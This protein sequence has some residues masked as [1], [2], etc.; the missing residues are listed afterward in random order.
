M[1]AA[2]FGFREGVGVESLQDALHRAAGDVTPTLLATHADKRAGLTGLAAATGLAFVG[3]PEAALVAQQTL[4]Q[5]QASQTARRTG[6][7]AEASALAAA[8]PGARLLGPRQ[9]SADR[10]AT[11]ALAISADAD[12]D[13]R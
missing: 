6:S 12:G 2:G 3:L 7:V 13:D 8:G 10:R 4:T 9:I 1:I 11:C 5:S